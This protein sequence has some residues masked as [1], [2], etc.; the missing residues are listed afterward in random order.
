VLSG[1]AGARGLVLRAADALNNVAS[2]RGEA[3]TVEPSGRR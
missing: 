3:P 1:D 2:A